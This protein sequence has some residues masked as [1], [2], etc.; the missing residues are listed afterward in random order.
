MSDDDT[1]DTMEPVRFDSGD[2]PV[3]AFMGE[4]PIL[5]PASTSLREA[6]RALHEGDTGLIVVGTTTAVEGVISERDIVRAVSKAVDLDTATVAEVETK[7]LFW[8]TEEST[9]AAVVEEMMEDY[10]RHILIG[11]A[12]GL[13]GIVSMRDLLAAYLD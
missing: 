7:D 3:T 11:H 9:V 5:I 2:A 12:G 10:V 6:A 1:M 8:A 4:E 13:V